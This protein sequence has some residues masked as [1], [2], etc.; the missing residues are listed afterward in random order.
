MI[1]DY[2]DGSYEYRKIRYHRRPLKQLIPE[3]H[4]RRRNREQVR[5]EEE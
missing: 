4:N 3:L 5:D 1:P 2:V